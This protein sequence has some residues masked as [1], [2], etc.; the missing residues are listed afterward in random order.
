MGG[1]LPLG[2]GSAEHAGRRHDDIDGRVVVERRDLVEEL[3]VEGETDR[4]RVAAET[5]QQAVV[6]TAALPDPVASGIER[7]PR[8]ECGV[9]AFGRSDGGLMIGLQDPVCSIHEL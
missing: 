1:F 6:V 3:L 4:E 2:F 5:R 7:D 8:H 9:D